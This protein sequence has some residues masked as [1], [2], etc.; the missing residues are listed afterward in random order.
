M[1][2]RIG[3]KVDLLAADQDEVSSPR[4]WRPDYDTDF[5]LLGWTPATYDAHNVIRAI[6]ASRGRLPGV[7]TT[8]N[9][10]YANARVDELSR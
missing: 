4:S 9:A 5:Y 10:G 3:I 6:L 7:G 1:L 8:N 2:A